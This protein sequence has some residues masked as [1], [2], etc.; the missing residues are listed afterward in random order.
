MCLQVLIPPDYL[1]KDNKRVSCSKAGCRFVYLGWH[2]LPQLTC[3]LKPLPGEGA[4]NLGRPRRR[5]FPRFRH[6]GRAYAHR[7]L[8]A[9]PDPTPPQCGRGS[10]THPALA[11]PQRLPLQITISEIQGVGWIDGHAAGKLLLQGAISN[12][13]S[14]CSILLT[15][16]HACPVLLLSF[17][18]DKGKPAQLKNWLAASIEPLHS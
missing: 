13:I 8:R 16:H 15:T 10:R 1:T 4:P 18:L 9:Q 6:R 12:L 11:P 7:L 14:L 5:L 2:I 17:W 3:L